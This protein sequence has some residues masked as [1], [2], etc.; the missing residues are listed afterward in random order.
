M[1]QTPHGI[2]FPDE[3]SQWMAQDIAQFRRDYYANVPDADFPEIW[4]FIEDRYLTNYLEFL[5]IAFEWSATGLWRIPF[6]GSVG[7]GECWGPD[8]I[9]LPKC[10]AEELQAWHDEIDRNCDPSAPDEFDW[11]ASDTE[12]LA[13]AKKIKAFVGVDHY[14]EFHPFREL[15]IVDGEVIE[16]EVPEFIGNL[17]DHSA[18]RA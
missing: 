10:I 5:L 8:H 11:V 6:P 2:K 7:M 14:V 17:N 1:I 15:I 9:G 13:L 4:R 16:A 12:G 18:E 3:Y